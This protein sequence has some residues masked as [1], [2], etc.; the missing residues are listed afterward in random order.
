M[1]HPCNDQSRMI[2]PEAVTMANGGKSD[3][4]GTTAGRAYMKRKRAGAVL[5][6]SSNL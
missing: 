3:D 5:L 2:F 4:P 6:K 1:R